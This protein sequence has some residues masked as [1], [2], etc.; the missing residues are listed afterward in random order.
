M[1]PAREELAIGAVV[2][3]L[4]GFLARD[5]NL[6]TL[7][8]Y[9][10]SRSPGIV[11]GALL[12]ALLWRTRLRRPFAAAVAALALCFALVTLTPLSAWLYRGL[13]RRD[14]LGPADAVFVSSSRIQDDGEMTTAAMNRLLRGLEV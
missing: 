2:G 7:W 3:A 8:S 1:R 11:M 14:A 12:G 6:A 9:A 5:L 13:P 10:G 4:G